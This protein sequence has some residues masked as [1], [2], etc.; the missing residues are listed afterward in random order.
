MTAASIYRE[1]TEA[2][3]R[4]KKK[5]PP[6]PFCAAV[7]PAAGLARRMEGAD[8]LL[9]ELDGVPVIVHT[10]LALERCPDISEIVVVTAPD[11]IIPVS[12][13]VRR[14]EIGKVSRIVKGGKNRVNSVMNGLLEISPQARLAAIHDGARPLATP[15]L[16][17]AAVRLAAVTGAA[18]PAVPPKDTLKQVK[19]GYVSA[20]P[21]RAGLA[22]IQTPQVFDAGLIK[23]ALARAAAEEWDITDDCSAVERMGMNVALS[24]GSYENIKVTTPEDLAI[25]EALLMRRKSAASLL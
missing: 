1:T 9:C 23:G 7:V 19:D 6:P 18:A 13:L 21:D 10:L 8:K 16:I 11:A 3:R 12:A 4:N 14:Y 24:E 5:Q 15:S 17:S 25:C 22:L 20:T 2:M